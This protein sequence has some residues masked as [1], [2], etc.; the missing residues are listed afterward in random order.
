MSISTTIE[1]LDNCG[2]CE[3]PDEEYLQWNDVGDISS[4]MES[5]EIR[6]EATIQRR[7]LVRP[8]STMKIGCWNVRTMY[9]PGK[10]AVVTREMRKYDIEI[11][12]ISELRWTGFGRVKTRTNEVI[13][14]SGADDEHRRGVALILGRKAQ[15]CLLDWKP[16]SDR[17]IRARFSSKFIK[18]T[19]IQIYAPTNDAEEENKEEFYQQLQSEISN[20][21]TH[22]MLVVMGDANAKVGS[23]DELWR[24]TIGK[25]GIGEMNENGERFA[26]LCAINNLAIG[27]TL[28][29]HKLIHKWTWLSPNGRDRN[30]IDHITINGKFRRSLED[31][32]VMRGADASSD[33]YLVVANIKLKLKRCKKPTSCS[34]VIYDVAKL[35]SP[36]VKREFSIQLKNRFECLQIEDANENNTEVSNT[37]S[38]NQKWEEFKTVYN[39]TATAVLGKKKKE[40][41][42]WISKESWKAIDTRSRIKSQI[43]SAK[44]ERIRKARMKDYALQDKEVKKMIRNDK[45]AMINT[46]AREAETAAKKNEMKALYSITRKLSQNKKSNICG[47]RGKDGKLITE[48]RE[49]LARWKEHFEEVLNPETENEMELPGVYPLFG[50]EDILDIDTGPFTINEVKEAIEKTRSGKAPGD[51]HINAELLKS[52]IGTSTSQLYE[53]F[54][55]VK[56]HCEVPSDWKRSII[57]KVPKKGDLTICDNSRGISLLSVPGKIFGRILIERM[58]KGVDAKLRQEQ[59]GFRKGRGTT[60]QIFILRNIIEQSIEWQTSLYI[61]F[62]D[63]S[64]AFDSLSRSK[65]WAIL[66][67][68]GIPFEIIRLI[69]EIYEG[70][71]SCVLDNGAKSEWFEVRS[72]VR[73]GCVMSGFL[74]NIAVDWI[75]RN[76][77][78]D[79]ARGLRWK[80]TSV[81]EDLDYADDIALLSSTFQ[82]IQEKTCKLS[83][84]AAHT[85]LKINSKKTKIMRLN[86]KCHDNVSVNNKDIEEVDKFVYL[87]A[88]LTKTGGAGEDIN[89]RISLAR[90]AFLKLDP[91]WRNAAISTNTKLRVFKS[92]VLAVLLYNSETWRI[93]ETDK[94]KL[95]VFQRRCL[96]K[97]LRIFW[98]MKIT[99]DELYIKARMTPVSEQIWK[100]RWNLIGHILRRDVS[101]NMRVA[102]TWTPEGRRKRGRPPTTW[103]RTVEKERNNLGWKSWASAELAARDRQSWRRYFDSAS[104]AT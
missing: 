27:G 42:E 93:T 40:N 58:R 96:R 26:E 13:L 52:D 76:V 98:P 75:M 10:T 92:N 61:N 46:L 35:K 37:K 3:I 81:L 86:N 49:V 39:E 41:K 31:V 15:Q 77:T 74:F 89:R 78:E 48:E 12:G 72:G 56:E 51:D 21:P 83:D 79:K 66:R 102:L 28:F 32:R 30:Q 62:V 43:N 50:A 1:A 22:D 90:T 73:Q 67:N 6:Q 84:V 9:T 63:F 57:T 60:E 103:R 29:K 44:S 25:F 38:V 87:G 100:R 23:Q 68:Y 5:S 47:V 64:K 91:V 95:N 69:Q 34:G 2:V 53:L 101:N 14:Y 71:S 59:A 94:N 70:S 55:N 18:L 19:V 97:I 80:F 11:L 4:M 36:E 104:C 8:K 45:R 24:G 16:I 7:S 88:T 82:H 20:T 17:I 33:H 99:N 85:G 65:L 54:N